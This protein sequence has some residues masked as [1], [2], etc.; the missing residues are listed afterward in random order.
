MTGAVAAAVF[1]A[2]RTGNASLEQSIQ[3]DIFRD[4]MA[5]LL[6][7]CSIDPTWLHWKD[8]AVVKLA[9]SIYH[10]RAFDQLPLLAST[11]EHAGCDHAELLAHCRNGGPHVRGC[12][13]VDALLGMK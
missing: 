12:W 2:R 6:R 11:L 8:D 7:P 10:E 9:Q 5:N 13:V 1:A 3:A 4:V